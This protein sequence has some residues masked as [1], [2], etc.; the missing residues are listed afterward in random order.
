MTKKR[1]DI[2]IVG[3]GLIGS[4][5][6]LWL[7]KHS[8][9]SIALVERNTPMPK[10]EEPNQRVVAL[11]LL[12][13]NY[14]KSIDAFELLSAV[15][16]HSYN[17]MHVW[18]ENSNGEL[19]FDSDSFGQAQL[20]CMIDSLACNYTLQQLLIE[21]AQAKPNS[22]ECFFD[23][24]LQKL[25]RASGRGVLS[26]IGNKGDSLEISAQLI[27]A[28]DGAN[29]WCRQQVG[30]F[31]N[32][33][34]YKQRG[35]VARIETEES[36]EDCAWQHFLSSGPLAALPLANNQ[37]S[38]VWSADDQLA[39]ELLSLDDVQFEARLQHALEGRLGAVSLLSARAGFP[40]GSQQA[41]TYYKRNVV[42]VGDAA[43]S[44]H[45]LAGQGANLGFKD[46]FAL[47]HLLT[48]LSGNDLS[49]KQLG[50]PRLLEKYQRQRQRDNQQTDA[51][52]S[53]LHTSYQVEMPLWMAARGVGMN[54]LNRTSILREL[55]AKHAMGL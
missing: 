19:E 4:A 32:H 40:L 49:A 28:A 29:S 30:I 2:A 25:D 23:T 34:E 8:G 13:L 22:V 24:R 48:E 51:L 1:V 3:A 10:P 50:E 6:A 26:L 17:R 54:L 39:S 33:H 9:L 20:G 31:A 53:A 18:D 42:L 46:I 16:C 21:A 44:I 7:A 38:I 41:E 43:H 47:G 45:P 37:S 11:G 27:V 15:Q 52:M 36:H 12:A 5:L 35:I 55:L 14:L